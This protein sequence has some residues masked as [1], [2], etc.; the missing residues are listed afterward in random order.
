MGRS[1]K[2][3]HQNEDVYI[4][5]LLLQSRQISETAGA[6]G[7]EE[8]S[9]SG[10]TDELDNRRMSLRWRSESTVAPPTPSAGGS[11]GVVHGKVK[12]ALN[13]LK[14]AASGLTPAKREA[15]SSLRETTTLTQV[16]GSTSSGTQAAMRGKCSN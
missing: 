14:Y 16:S 10:S 4:T 15:N 7:R 2:R 1:D 6:A 11:R 3:K 13:S 5:V 8:V 9:M 12:W